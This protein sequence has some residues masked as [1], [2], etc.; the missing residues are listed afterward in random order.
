MRPGFL[1]LRLILQ[2]NEQNNLSPNFYYN[3]KQENFLFYFTFT[4]LYLE[5]TSADHETRLTAAEENIQGN[6]P[7]SVDNWLS[8]FLYRVSSER[9]AY[10][11]KICITSH[12]VFISYFYV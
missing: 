3:F 12:P 10:E 5:I 8:D 11:D 2:V 9:K 4:F 7:D 6:S 1:Q